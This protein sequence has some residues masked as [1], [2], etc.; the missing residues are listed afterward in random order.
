MHHDEGMVVLGE[1]P[2][3]LGAFGAVLTPVG[4]ARLTFPAEPFSR[5]E[6]WTRRWMPKATVRHDPAGLLAL[7]EQLTAYLEGALREFSVS[8]D[9]RG[10]PFQLAVWRELLGIGYGETRSYSQVAAAIDAGRAVRAVGVAN[11]ANPAPIIVPCHRVIGA[12]GRLTGYGGGLELKE[13]LLG[14]E[15]VT[16]HIPR[17][18]GRGGPEMGMANAS[19]RL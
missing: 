13:R 11:G 9:L 6:A 3:P 14:L 19:V 16:L 10:T 7:S 2:T 8:A 12:D 5:C 17:P 18:T 1:V 4:L 15:G